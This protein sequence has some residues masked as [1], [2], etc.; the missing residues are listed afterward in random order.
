LVLGPGGA[1]AWYGATM[2]W[3]IGG[4]V[5]G[6][7][8]GGLDGGWKGALMGAGIGGALG[9]FG[10]WGVGQYG[11]GFGAG[12][13][14]AGAGVAG[15]TNSWDSFAGGITGALAGTAIGNGIN[16]FY[17][18]FTG[19]GQ[20]G[21]NR[22][23]LAAQTEQLKQSQ[24]ALDVKLDEQIRIGSRDAVGPADHMFI[25]RQNGNIVEMG[26]GGGKIRVFQY[27]PKD[28]MNPASRV[29]LASTQ[30]HTLSAL[31]DG[32][33]NLQWSDPTMVSSAGL[34]NLIKGYGNIWS[35]AVYAAGSNNSNYFVNT[36]VYGAGGQI[37]GL[38]VWRPSYSTFR[39]NK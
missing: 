31:Y 18:E 20:A 35:G 26:G 28:Y 3:A 8:S 36:C 30:R 21:V 23:D 9:G 24:R 12:M 27:N 14:V 39:D 1:L 16:S 34:N 5:G 2:S 37:T 15:A 25:E 17:N 38:D 4:A 10:A 7:I 29:N 32:K 13:L 6:A 33:L 22:N 11:W 19:A